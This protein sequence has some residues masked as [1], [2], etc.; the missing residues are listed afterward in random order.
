ML[1]ANGFSWQKDVGWCETG[2]VKRKRKED[3]VEVTDPDAFEDLL[4]E[5]SSVPVHLFVA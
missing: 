4:R 3:V 2:P 5:L 1:Q